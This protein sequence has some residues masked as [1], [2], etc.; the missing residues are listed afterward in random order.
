MISPNANQ[1][2]LEKAEYS[3]NNTAQIGKTVAC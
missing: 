1:R 2:D 3:R